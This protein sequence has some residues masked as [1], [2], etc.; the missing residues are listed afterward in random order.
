MFGSLTGR[1][2]RRVLRALLRTRHTGGRCGGNHVVAE[3]LPPRRVLD[4]QPFVV[5]VCVVQQQNW[6][7]GAVHRGG[8]IPVRVE[9]ENLNPYPSGRRERGQEGW[10][11]QV[12]SGPLVEV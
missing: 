5:V 12:L 1:V 9:R 2:G 3:R 7:G 8:V 11:V 4:G 6:P 10:I